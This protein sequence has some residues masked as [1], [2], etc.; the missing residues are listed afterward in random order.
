[1]VMVILISTVNDEEKDD[2]FKEIISAVNDK[3]LNIFVELH[4]NILNFQV[5]RADFLRLVD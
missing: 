4:A 1:M 3:V 2:H 5:D